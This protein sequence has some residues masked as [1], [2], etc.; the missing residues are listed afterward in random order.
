MSEAQ[1]NLDA[2]IKSADEEVARAAAS[3][4]V[5]AAKKEN[6]QLQLELAY[7]E[8]LQKTFKAVTR[9]LVSFA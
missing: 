7:R 2:T 1:S 5:F 8:R 4:T 3:P 9:R 6:V